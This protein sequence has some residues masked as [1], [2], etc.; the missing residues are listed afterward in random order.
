[1]GGHEKVEVIYLE[2]SLVLSKIENK[3]GIIEILVS[4]VY[5]KC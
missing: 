3:I 5:S 1:V 4:Y 2:W